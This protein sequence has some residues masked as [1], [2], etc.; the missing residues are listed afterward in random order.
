MAKLKSAD[1]VV[2]PFW[3]NLRARKLKELE[4]TYQL[5]RI[6][7]LAFKDPRALR[8]YKDA[9]EC[10]IKYAEPLIAGGKDLLDVWL[11][12]NERSRKNNSDPDRI[13]RKFE[14]Q[15]A[16]NDR[17]QFAFIEV[18]GFGFHNC[19]NAL[20]DYVTYDEAPARE[21]KKLLKNV[22]TIRCDEP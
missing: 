16:S 9:T 20:I 8:E 17:M 22:K 18:M 14:E 12:V 19:A 13:R 2:T 15:L 3:Q 7:M 11:S 10:S 5:S 21:F 6:E 1:I 4:Q